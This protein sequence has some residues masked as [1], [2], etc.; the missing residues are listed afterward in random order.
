M[1]TN[2]T[3]V[4]QRWLSRPASEGRFVQH[5]L[6][7]ASG[8]LAA[9]FVTVAAAPLLARSYSPEAFGIFG[10]LI[11][12]GAVLGGVSGLKYE[13]A[14]VLEREEASA[15]DA[16]RL[17]LSIAAAFA[18]VFLLAA[19]LVGSLSNS[20][21]DHNLLLLLL[22]V[23]VLF[24][25]WSMALGFWATRHEYWAVQAQGVLARNLGTAGCQ[26]GLSLLTTGPLGLVAGRVVGEL[27]MLVRL[28]HDVRS[29][30]A[31]GDS[32]AP[33]HLTEASGSRLRTL[34]AKHRELPLYQA[35]R[36]FLRSATVHLPALLLVAFASPVVAGL[37]WF[38]SRLLRML[39]EMLGNAV[40][41]VFFKG[42][43]AIHQEGN[44]TRPFLIRV[45]VLLGIA[46]LAPMLGLAAEG[47][48]LFAFAFGEEWRM[49]GAYARWLA[50]WS[51]LELIAAPAGMLVSVHSIQRPFL[52]A[53]LIALSTGAAALILAA[54]SGRHELAV[55]LYVAV[56]A[57]RCLYQIGFMLVRTGDVAR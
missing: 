37:Y 2:T 22:P 56:M 15:S 33:L 28:W 7:L 8:T 10:A 51:W 42:A 40:R 34:A 35:P 31:A 52:W 19:A 4:F 6:T 44:G 54:W 55:G 1:P 50:L 41:R 49:A 5:V 30:G 21:P 11:G 45:T 20:L 27:L 9:Q 25:G 43:V 16:L 36:A 29:R 47:P 32:R 13:L 57:S 23:F 48:A 18:V 53:D 38:A 46:G 17:T 14:I 24:S 39:V 3:A 12:L 26:L